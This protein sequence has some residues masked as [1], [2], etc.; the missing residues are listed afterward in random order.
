MFLGR[1]PVGAGL[2][3]V[4]AA[5]GDRA[6]E[7]QGEAG[8]GGLGLAEALGGEE[9]CASASANRPASNTTCQ[10]RGGSGEFQALARWKTIELRKPVQQRFQNSIA[11]WYLPSA[12]GNTP[13]G[14]PGQRGGGWPAR[15][16]AS[17]NVLS[18]C[19]TSPP[20]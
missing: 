14:V 17:R 10:A 3:S 9:A 19:S 15:G 18:A 12:P 20:A 16:Q 13:P 1:Q 4:A 2:L 6:E 5:E 8:F 11:S 7:I